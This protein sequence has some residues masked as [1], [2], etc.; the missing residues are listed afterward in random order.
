MSTRGDAGAASVYVLAAVLLVGILAASVSL[1]AAG[2]ALHR[3]AVR[4]ADLGALAGAQVVLIDPT[5]ACAVAHDV[6]MANGG[7][8]I[9]C[10]AEPPTLRVVVVMPTEVPWLPPI[11]ASATAGPR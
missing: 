5:E 2:L 6:A 9:D 3:Q 10:V 7:L 1:V 11:R 4:A 8:V